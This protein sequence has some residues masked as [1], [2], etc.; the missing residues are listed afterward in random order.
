MA[1][2]H[3]LSKVQYVDGFWYVMI[4]SAAIGQ[5]IPEAEWLTKEEAEADRENWL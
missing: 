2:L 4:L 3:E 1:T 5:W